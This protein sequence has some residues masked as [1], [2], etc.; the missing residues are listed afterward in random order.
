VEDTTQINLRVPE[1]LKVAIEERRTKVGISRNA[2][3]VRAL[4]WAVEQPVTSRSRTHE[5]K[6]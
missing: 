4:R 3:M 6:V 2:W 5:E 1:D